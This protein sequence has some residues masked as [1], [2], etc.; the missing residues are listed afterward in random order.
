M[1]SRKIQTP[2]SKPREKASMNVET[3]IQ[4]G[5]AENPQIQLVL[6]IAQRARELEFREPPRNIGMATDVVATPTNSQYPV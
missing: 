3:I 1:S 6:D 2:K 5:L 4:K